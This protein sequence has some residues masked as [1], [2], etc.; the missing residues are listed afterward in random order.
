M[1]EDYWID[2]EGDLPFSVV[3]DS[4][5]TRGYF[6]GRNLDYKD[7][8]F[9]SNDFRARRK[10]SFVLYYTIVDSKGVMDDTYL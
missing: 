2:R 5:Y 9:V 10:G 1:H 8:A 3:P 4:W 7:G 6:P